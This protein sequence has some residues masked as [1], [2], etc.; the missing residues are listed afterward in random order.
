MQP[1]MHN[2]YLQY[3]KQILLC[4]F[5]IFCLNDEIAQDG[6]KSNMYFEMN[7]MMIIVIY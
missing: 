7:L 5:D 1:E 2:I 4:V 6:S 3:T